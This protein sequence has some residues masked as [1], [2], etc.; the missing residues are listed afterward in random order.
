MAQNIYNED[1]KKYTLQE[2]FNKVNNK[3]LFQIKSKIFGNCI[4]GTYEYIKGMLRKD[5]FSS[6]IQAI[7]TD[8]YGTIITIR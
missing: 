7:D 5:L 2:Y 4:T 3:G 8:E 6:C 1:G